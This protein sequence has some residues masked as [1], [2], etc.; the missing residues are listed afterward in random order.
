MRILY[1]T[2]YFP[3]EI[4]ATQTRA[5][6]MA[7]GLVQQG[8]QVTLLT[9]FPNHPT[10]IIPPEYRGKR[11]ERLDIEGIDVIRLWVKASPHKSFRTRI[12]FYISYMLMAIWA[13]LWLVRGKYDV[14]YATSPPLFTGGA[15]LALSYLKRTP[16]IFE[17]RD[18]WPESAVALGEVSNRHAI[19]I[20]TWLEEACYRR[21][22]HIVTASQGM[23]RKIAARGF[24]AGKITAI[25]NGA[26]T[27]LYQ[28]QPPH[29]ELRHRLGFVPDDFVV[30]YTG[31]HG[32]AH[33]LE[34]AVE[35]A[36]LLHN[37]PHIK[38]LFIGDGPCKEQVVALAESK[39][40]SNILFYPA[41]AEPLL[42]AYIGVGDL[43][44]DTR[45]KVSITEDTLPVKMFT[46]MACARPVLLAISGE[47]LEL[48]RESQAGVAVPPEE[49]AALA[50]AILALYEDADGR[51]QMAQNGL[52]YVRAHYSRQQ[53]AQRLGRLLLEII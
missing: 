42:P 32:L 29:P 10:G 34:T 31:L 22:R 5:Y 1:L 20:A 53:L 33:G 13:G 46:Y 48:L 25:P 2:Q 50:E 39:K 17:V 9:E 44:L 26:N 18:L 24:D 38:F 21:A 43:G 36:A 7:R 52:A 15:G 6:E 45:R 28:P 27:E 14:V 4:G 23:R 8:H 40:L 16:L 49:P 41:V 19:R 47:A 37:Y 30:M 35:A 11:Y 3:P 51:A 12:V